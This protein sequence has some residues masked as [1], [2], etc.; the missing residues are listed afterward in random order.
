[1]NNSISIHWFRQD[2]RLKDNPA[3]HAA[4]SNSLLIPLYHYEEDIDSN[5]EIGSAGKVWLHNSLV[6]LNNSLNNK[7]C[8]TKGS[9]IDEIFKLISIYKVEKVYWNFC[10]EPWRI[11]QDQSL[12]IQ[13]EEKGIDVK[14][15]NG[16]YL[17]SQNS[18][19]KDDGT[20]YKVF[21]P[22]YRKGCLNALTPR[23]PLKKPLLNLV[24]TNKH[25]LSIK[26]LQLLPYKGWYESFINYWE[27]G[28]NGAQKKL[29]IF[30]EHGLSDYKEGRNFPEKPYVSRLSPH[31]HWGELSPNQAWYAVENNS[32]EKNIDHFRSELGWREFSA[33]LLYN[34]PSLQKN[35]LQSKFDRF[36][37]NHNHNYLDSWKKGITGIPIVDAGM[38][39]L[40]ETG[41]MHNRVRMIVGSF[42][43]KNL[44]IDWRHGESWFRDCLLDADHANNSASWQWI[45]GCGADAAPYFRIFNPITQGKKFDSAGHYTKKFVPELK[46]LPSDYLFNPWEAPD[47]ILSKANIKLGDSY[48]YPIVDLK[49][50]RNLALSA[51]GSLKDASHDSK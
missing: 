13:L 7:L 22:Y 29:D 17:W 18:I 40:W 23:I 44:L 34:Y 48:P 8:I 46:H 10:V 12:K 39:E 26:D 37:W 31:L 25:S 38:R 45:A 36:P 43:V 33:Y 20:N 32:S 30:V 14:I 5:D 4:Q 50:S 49:E 9:I 6:S 41:Y 51:F 2:L 11:Q 19:K 1:M 35:N 3:L 27:Y 15:Y 24:E 16:S 42:L 47:D 21:T 28:E